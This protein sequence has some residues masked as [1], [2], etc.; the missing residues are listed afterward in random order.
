[1]GRVFQVLG[2]S[3]LLLTSFLSRQAF[4]AEDAEGDSSAHDTKADTHHNT[5][6]PKAAEQP[7]P[8]IE[9]N[10]TTMTAPAAAVAPPSVEVPLPAKPKFGDLSISGYF[11]GGV[12]AS[13]G[14]GRMTCFALANQ[15]GLV[16]KWRLGNE[17]EVWSETH[18]TIVTYAGDDGVTASVHV[19]PTVYIPT[20]YIGYSPAG[21]INSPLQFTTSTGAVLYFPNLYV[22][23]RGIPW[24]F[25]GTAWAGTRYYKRES[26][27]ISD[28]FYWNP[29]GVGA[30]IEDISLGQ[31]VPALDGMRFSYGAFAVD[32]EPAAPADPSAPQLPSQTDFGVRSDVQLRGIH[33]WQTGELQLGFQ[34]IANYSNDPATSGGWGATLQFVQMVLGGDNKLAFQYGKGGGTGFGTLAR[35]Y[36]PDFSLRHDPSE[37]RLR[38]VEVLTIQPLQWLGGQLAG[39]YQYDNNFLGNPGLKS[40]WYAAGG[41][42]AL[43][44]ARHAKLLGEAG[45]DRVVRSGSPPEYLA[46]FTGAIALTSDRGFLSRPELRLFYTWAVWNDAAAMAPVDSGRLYTDTYPNLRSGSIFG[47]SAETWY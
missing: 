16:S 27:Y 34:Y 5:E 1:M 20:T 4:A 3:G 36:Y 2:L 45:Y 10:A 28:F 19:M 32:G 38:I 17:C 47:V 23:I 6:E 25:G 13:N 31:I 22:D 8:L 40:T 39:V 35:F 15:A 37:S 11:R 33:P 44:F 7:A 43:A 42:A 46:K 29:S 30:G 24:L 26:I 21:A 18:F 12:G 14:K 41:R 9:P